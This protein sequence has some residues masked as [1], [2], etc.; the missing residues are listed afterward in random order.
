ME[1]NKEGCH[2]VLGG[3][4]VSVLTLIFV[5][6]KLLGLINWS[7]WLVFSPMIISFSLG[8]LV[9]IILAILYIWL[10]S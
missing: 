10:G 5:V 8:C 2:I 7:W 3:W 1:N 4:F 9:L 6:A